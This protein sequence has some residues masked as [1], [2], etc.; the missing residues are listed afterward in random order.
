MLDREIP[1]R[2][3]IQRAFSLVE[4]LVVV[5]V[6]GILVVVALP[7]YQ[8]SANLAKENAANANARQIAAAVQSIYVRNGGDGYQTREVPARQIRTELGGAIPINP[9]TGGRNLRRDYG[10]RRQGES[11]VLQPVAGRGCNASK[12]RLLQ[13]GEVPVAD[14]DN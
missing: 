4:L 10:L 3:L 11:S 1:N 7:N 2:R 13:L 6:L 5:L 14:D 12:L 8:S 9:C